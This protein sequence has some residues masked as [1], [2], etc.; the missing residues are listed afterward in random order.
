MLKIYRMSNIYAAQYK[1]TRQ[2]STQGKNYGG[3]G[4]KADGENGQ[5]AK[6]DC[7]SKQQ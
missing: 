5:H 7:T 1:N 6:Q 2:N 3:E 4:I